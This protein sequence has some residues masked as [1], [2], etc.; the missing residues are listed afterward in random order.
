MTISISKSD[1]RDLRAILYWLKKEYE[2]DDRGHGYWCNRK[3]IREAHRKG[4]LYVLREDNKCVAFHFKSEGMGILEVRADKRGRGYGKVLIELW[5][6]RA[7]ADGEVYIAVEC[8]P[9]TSVS[10]W[11]MMGF[12]PIRTDNGQQ[13][14][15]RL[16]H[17]RFTL[18]ADAE[19]VDVQISFYNSLEALEK[20]GEPM[21]AHCP[22]ATKVGKSINLAERVTC[23]QPFQDGIAVKVEVDGKI[24]YV[25]RARSADAKALGIQPYRKE[26]YTAF[27]CDQLKTSA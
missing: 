6:K 1:E 8:A 26:F 18:D 9:E 14:A 5:I 19:L 13:F 16:L 7:V 2:A 27:Y 3:Y 15:Y 11:Q 4:E 23:L 21:A 12:T 24:L 25:G 20:G 17:K 22:V 10:F